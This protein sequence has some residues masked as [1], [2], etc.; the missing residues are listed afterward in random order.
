[1]VLRPISAAAQPSSTSLQPAWP[2][3]EETQHRA[4]REFLLITQPDH[5]AL[6]GAIAAALGPPLLPELTAEVVQGIAVHDDGWA[7]FDARTP[8]Q[9]G[10]PVSFIDLPPATFLQAWRGSIER[11]A[12]VAPIAGA[13]VSRHFWRLGTGHMKSKQDSPEDERALRQFLDQENARQERLTQGYVRREFEFL[14]DVLQFC[15]VLSLYL[16]CGAEQDVEFPQSF[17][18]A[19]VRLMRVQKESAAVCRFD[20]SPFRHGTDLAVMARRFPASGTVQLPFL[21][22]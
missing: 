16:C 10:K 9:S 5:A 1:M 20:P 8:C 6:A 14:T 2:A 22:Y 13:I 17:S 4:A 19:T 15:D 12:E 3:I 11:A 18:G 21:L 7:E